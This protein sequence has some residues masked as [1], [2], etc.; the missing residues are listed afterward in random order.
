MNLL[1]AN[2]FSCKY[3]QFDIQ[4]NNS[5]LILLKRNNNWKII[6]LI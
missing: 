6:K 4:P 3:I 2:I 5:N 1:K